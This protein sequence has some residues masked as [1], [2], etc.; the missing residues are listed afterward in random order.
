MIFQSLTPKQGLAVLSLHY[1]L[2]HH[3][4]FSIQG[5]DSAKAVALIEQADR[6]EQQLVPQHQSISDEFL[7]INSDPQFPI[8]FIRNGYWYLYQLDEKNPMPWRSLILMSSLMT[9]EIAGGIAIAV[10][11][12]G[13]GLGAG[14]ALAS[15]GISDLMR[16]I[17]IGQSRQF[18]VGQTFL[19]K[20]ISLSLGLGAVGL[21]HAF[22]AGQNASSIMQAT[23]TALECSEVAV[24]AALL[25]SGVRVGAKEILMEMAKRTGLAVVESASLNAVEYTIEQTTSFILSAIQVDLNRNLTEQ[26]HHLFLDA[27][28]KRVFKKIF[29]ADACIQK[30]IASTHQDFIFEKASAIIESLPFSVAGLDVSDEMGLSKF[31][32]EF[33]LA[34]LK[35]EEEIH[36]FTPVLT[37]ALK[38][39]YDYLSEEEINRI[40]KSIVDCLTENQIL[41]K[42]G[43]DVEKLKMQWTMNQS[44]DQIEVRDYF[45]DKYQLDPT[46]INHLQ[47][48]EEIKHYKLFAIKK[49]MI[50]V[51]TVQTLSDY[52]YQQWIVR[53]LPLFFERA[54]KNASRIAD[55]GKYVANKVGASAVSA[56]VK[57]MD[58]LISK[59]KS[60]AEALTTQAKSETQTQEIETPAANIEVG[61][62]KI[63]SVAEASAPQTQQQSAETTSTGANQNIPSTV[64]EKVKKGKGFFGFGKMMKKMKEV[65]QA[66]AEESQ[67]QQ[68][69]SSESSTL[70]ALSDASTM[71]VNLEKE[72]IAEMASAAM[73]NRI[74]SRKWEL[75]NKKDSGG[76]LAKPPST[77]SRPPSSVN[78]PAPVAV[79]SPD[80]ASYFSHSGK[81][82]QGASSQNRPYIKPPGLVS[83]RPHA[84]FAPSE[85]VFK[86]TDQTLMLAIADCFDQIS[87]AI[88]KQIMDDANQVKR[89]IKKE[90]D[91]HYKK[92]K[93]SQENSF[94]KQKSMLKFR[95]A[96]LII[97]GLLFAQ[98][99]NLT[100][101]SSQE[102]NRI[103][104]QTQ[105]WIP[106]NHLADACFT[107]SSSG[108][109]L[110]LA[111]ARYRFVLMELKFSSKGIT[112]FYKELKELKLFFI[113]I[114]EHEM[115]LPRVDQAILD[116]QALFNQQAIAALN[117]NGNSNQPADSNAF[118]SRQAANWIT[119]G[120]QGGVNLVNSNLEDAR[121][122]DLVS[123]GHLSGASFTSLKAVGMISN[124][125]LAACKS[126]EA[127]AHDISQSAIA[128][129]HHQT[130]LLNSLVA[131]KNQQNAILTKVE[132][133]IAKA[134]TE[135][136]EKVI[137]LELQRAEEVKGIREKME[138]IR[139]K[140]N[141]IY[142]EAEQAGKEDITKI[143]ERRLAQ[144]E[145]D[146]ASHQKSIDQLE[147]VEKAKIIH[148]S[149][150]ALNAQNIELRKHFITTWAKGDEQLSKF[151]ESAY[152]SSAAITQQCISLTEKI[153]AANVGMVKQVLDYC[154]EIKTF[155]AWKKKKSKSTPHVEEVE[156]VNKAILPPA[157]TS[158]SG[159]NPGISSTQPSQG[160]MFANT[161]T[162]S[163]AQQ[164]QAPVASSTPSPTPSTN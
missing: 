63:A 83:I 37:H 97:D 122:A 106:A 65:A 142:D 77:N 48:R 116:K 41:T 19:Q 18:S 78:K 154:K 144:L 12:G 107:V 91:L 21:S 8:E 87:E 153:A 131:L 85:N 117:V 20:G 101:K 112:R 38:R 150:H 139:S 49:C 71:Q 98:L 11:S 140:M 60:T 157:P 56:G 55:V 1:E 39:K 124:C 62:S 16:L 104:W 149:L 80:Q 103:D 73:Q 61:E 9:L 17:K 100:L 148:D 76:L 155:D 163:G 22:S 50:Y 127:I 164:T 156:D 162:Q 70:Q 113:N 53:L 43:I 52:L 110:Q 44:V 161:A 158:T 64:G 29:A 145:K 108:S 32:H 5:L 146:I 115:A 10:L 99:E 132:E 69:A 26:V 59:P 88:K 35:Q 2:H 137:K 128:I 3:I 125:V 159:S 109:P 81:I 160:G 90:F 151:I 68:S 14:L 67:T 105:V 134:A 30:N 129:Q 114:G 79:K 40:S 126:N 23:D 15:E 135:V 34:L 147:S 58:T 75:S 45:F 152:A 13:A 120:V 27:R 92:I 118:W 24:N 136:T 123:N 74:Q 96:L 46:V 36:S 7:K 28:W 54:Q 72:K 119:T 51:E 42:S 143:Q 89:L 94:K 93:S 57:K 121:M 95:L 66:Q 138:E 141:A 84:H 86:K 111:E 31:K 102:I 33:Y 82:P 133:S 47:W 25:V 6:L 4:Q 130:Q